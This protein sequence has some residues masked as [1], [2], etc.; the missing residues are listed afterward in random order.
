MHAETCLLKSFSTIFFE[1]KVRLVLAN[2]QYLST[3]AD[4][5]IEKNN[6]CII[7]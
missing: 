5:I 2:F 1:I 6:V 4:D 3:N 7:Q